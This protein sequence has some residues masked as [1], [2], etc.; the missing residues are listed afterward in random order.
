MGFGQCTEK[1]AGAP[2]KT[3]R[4]RCLGSRAR[5]AADREGWRPG[6]L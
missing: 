5:A 1:V 6:A 3:Q 2:N 4:I